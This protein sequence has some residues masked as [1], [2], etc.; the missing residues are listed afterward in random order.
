MKVYKFTATDTLTPKEVAEIMQVTIVA[1]LQA[2]QQ[3]PPTGAEP[4]EIDEAIYVHLAPNLKRY[5]SESEVP[6]VSPN[7]PGQ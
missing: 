5:F 1:L 6:D 3:R 4:L 7:Q 2:I